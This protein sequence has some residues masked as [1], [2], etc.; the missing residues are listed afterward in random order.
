MPNTPVRAAAEGTPENPEI[1]IKVRRLANELSE[2][3]AECDGGQ[4]MAEIRPAKDDD[5]SS[6][7]VSA[8]TLDQAQTLLLRVRSLNELLYQAG[9]GMLARN[10]KTANA[11][12]TGC[13]VIDGLLL[14]IMQ[15]LDGE[16]SAS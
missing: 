8:E 1:W 5:N 14:Q 12:S 2:A 9:E 15:L 10:S 3:L 6:A 11:I 13:D 7:S 16:G 4:W